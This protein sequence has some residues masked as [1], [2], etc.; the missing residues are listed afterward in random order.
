MCHF[1]FSI[2]HSFCYLNMSLP[3]YGR[4]AMWRSNH[5]QHPTDALKNWA[6]RAQ[7][8]V[9]WSESSKRQPDNT[10]VHTVLPYCMFAS[11]HGTQEQLLTFCQVTC[12]KCH[13]L[14][15]NNGNT[16]TFTYSDASQ[17]PHMSNLFVRDWASRN[18]NYELMGYWSVDGGDRQVSI[19]SRYIFGS[20]LRYP[21]ILEPKSFM[22]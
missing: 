20:S 18:R 17:I 11:T 1:R 12:R 2:H 4:W 19:M 16:L 13:P 7:A 15:H 21:D 22:T 5:E 14:L 9:D 8:R 6:T 3:P 10:V